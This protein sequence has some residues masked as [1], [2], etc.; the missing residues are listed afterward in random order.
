MRGDTNRGCSYGKNRLAAVTTCD[1]IHFHDADDELMPNFVERAHVWMA[2][3]R[4]D[5]VLFGFEERQSGMRPSIK[6]WRFDAAALKTDPRS[7]VIENQPNAICGLY[8]RKAFLETGGY[9]EDPLVLYNEDA[10]FHIRLAFHGLSFAADETVAIINH[11]RDGSMSAANGLRCLQAQYHVLHGTAQLAGAEHYAG[12]IA[13]RLWSVVAGLAAHLDWRTA[14]EAGLLA[15]RLAG[16]SS[17]PGRLFRFLCYGSPRLAI[18][19]RESLI[20]TFKPALRVA[21]PEWKAAFL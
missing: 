7:Y 10:A 14:D 18:R 2:E 21:Y 1:W 12:E 13:R 4:F 19:A 20:R 6:I 3:G 9:E 16:P 17:A 5:V 8:R 11:R 15:I